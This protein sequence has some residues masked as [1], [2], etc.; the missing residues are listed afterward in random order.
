MSTTV[1]TGT[2][3]MAP[4]AS[5]PWRLSRVMPLIAPSASMSTTIIVGV[6]ATTASKPGAVGSVSGLSTWP[7]RLS[8]ATS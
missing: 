7:W 5:P 2:D 4:P 3:T 8:R 1:P 6:G